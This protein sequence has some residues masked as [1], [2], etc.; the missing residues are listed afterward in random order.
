MIKTITIIASAI[1]MFAS[2]TS[3]QGAARAASASDATAAGGHKVLVA[4]FSCTGTTEAVARNVAAATGGVLYRITPKRPYTEA[5]LDWHNTASRSSVEM[6]DDASRPE[7]AAHDAGVEKYD[8]V[9]LGYPIWWNLSPRIINSF[10]EAYNFEGKT[11]VP[12]ATS[13][14]SSI[15]NSVSEL[16]KLYGNGINWLDGRLLNSGGKD[17]EEWAASCVD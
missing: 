12:F 15:D 5:D 7:L 9:F 1:M 11:V 6:K 10:L 4:Y 17:A 16:R 2:C 8:I 13:G 14:G 3:R